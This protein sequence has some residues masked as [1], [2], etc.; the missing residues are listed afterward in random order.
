MITTVIE[1]HEDKETLM[2]IIPVIYNWCRNSEK[3]FDKK[4]IV[5]K[6]I[7]FYWVELGKL[8]LLI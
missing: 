2:C 1:R 7:S 4:G 6:W 3:S 8:I 5:Y